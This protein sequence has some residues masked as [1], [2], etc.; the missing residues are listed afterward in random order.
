MTITVAQQ[1]A[2]DNALVPLEKRVEIGKCNMR[3]NPAKTQKEPTYQV[4]LDALALT[5]CYPAFIITADV[6]EIYM[7]QFWFTI[8]KKDFT[9]YKFKIDKKS[10]I[11]DMEVFREIF[12]ICPR[13]SNKDFDELPSD[14]ESVSFIKELRHK[15][16]NKSVTEVVVDQIT[17]VIEEEEGPKPAK[18]AKAPAKAERSKGNELLSDATLHE[19]AQLKKALR[20]S[21]RDTTIHQANG[22]SEGANSE[23]EVP[24]E[25]KGKSKDTGKGTGLKPRVLDVSTVD[26]SKSENESWGD[27]GDEAN[28]QSDDEDEQKEETPDDE[29]V[30]TPDDYVPTDEETKDKIDDVTEEEYERIN[31]ELYGVVSISLTD[32]EPADK[33]KD[34]EEMTV[35]GH[36]NVNQEDAGNQ[37]KDDAHATQKTEGPIPSSFISSD[38]AAKYLNFDNIPS[39][40][41]EVVSM[42]DTNIQHEVLRTSP[43]LTISVSVIPEHTI[44]NPPEIVATT[45]SITISTLMSSLFPHLQQLISIPTTTTTEATT[46]TTAISD[47]E[48]LVAL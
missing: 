40:D 12:Q 30:Y 16:D 19:K 26:S 29:S 42:L 7:Q 48:M 35:A 15:G 4:V 20:R 45:S 37:V 44:A 28:E 5:T 41:T 25:Q 18:K 33:E 47:S 24:D 10:Y 3:I 1:V 9:T 39:V 22:S 31:E 13:I 2:P 34:D 14:D 36:V 32:D 21:K 43:L 17:L 11:I 27:S 38:Y 6:S 23:S 8:N 46:S